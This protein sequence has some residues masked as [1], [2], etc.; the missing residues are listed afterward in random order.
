MGE[1]KRNETKK[2]VMGILAHVD[3]GKTTL[4]EGI[5]YKSGAIRKV[6]RVDKQDTFL[7][8]E[9]Q[10]RARGITIFSKQARFHWKK[11]EVTLLD[12]PG[13]VDF[14][15]EMERTLQVLDYAILVISALD[16]VQGHTQTL[17]NLLRDYEIPTFLFINKMDQPG[18]DREK[19][20]AELRRRLDSGCVDFTDPTTE[21]F[22]ENVATCE[23]EILE[24]YLE[25]GEIQTEAIRDVIV[26]RKLFP[27]F[28][29]SALKLEGI[30]TLLDGMETYTE[31]MVY[32]EAFSARVFKITRDDQGNR[33]T[34]MKVT[35]GSLKVKEM[36]RALEWEEKVNQIRLYSGAKYEPVQEAEAG[37]VCAV[38]GLTKTKP[39]E[40]LGEDRNENI[41]VLEPVLTYRICLPDEVDASVMLPKLRML[42]EEDPML[43][44]DWKEDLQ[45]IHAK[46]MGE[47]QIEVLTNLVKNRF[48]IDIT[49]DEGNIVYKET[50]ANTVEG[51][52]HFEPLRH[53]AEVHLLME[54]GNPGSGIVIEADCSED[55]LDRNW[56][57]LILTHLYEREHEGVLI[58]APITDVKITLKAGK[59]HL[60][61]T[62]GGD[63][64]QAT[65]RAVRQ[66]LR[67]AESVLLEPWYDFR[68]ELPE[69]NIGR[70]MMDVEKM[71]GKA[72][73]DF[74]EEAGMQEHLPPEER[75][76][77]LT[78]SCPVASMRGYPVELYSYTK[79]RGRLFC[80]LKGYAPCHNAE[81]II[82]AVGYVPEADLMNPTGSVFCSHGAGVNIPWDEVKKHMHLPS[83][84]TPK[85]EEPEIGDWKSR[86]LEER[87][88]GEDEVE[89]ILNRTF[90]SNQSGKS[91]KRRYKKSRGDNTASVMYFSKEDRRRELS[92][93]MPREKREEYLLVDGYNIVFAWEELKKLAENNID[94]ARDKLLDILS[95]YQGYKKC[96]L[97]V[98]FD[99]YR[100][101]GHDTEVVP[102]HN[103]TVVYTK[104]AE[105]ADS[106]IEK[107]AHKN[108]R[109][110]E[111]TVATSDRL[112]QMIILG[113]GC[114]ALSARNL[115]EEVQL[116]EKE[117]RKELEQTASREKNTLGASLTK[118]HWEKLR[119]KV[120]E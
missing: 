72:S 63:F 115:L 29:G 43:S 83:I 48:G 11:M 110:Y 39:G 86:E 102:Y 62:E 64:R 50:I 51:V 3:A 57:R 10:E 47:V 16:G 7:D 56:Q 6:G 52:G 77:V 82:E 71:Y 42:E 88:I 119:E 28:F 4:S 54:P 41:P 2:L 93:S 9:E 73:L 104:E 68:M 65:Y 20:L 107:F 13:H 69:T 12:T 114:R 106:F 105:T 78:G 85:K 97:M 17:W 21:E 81:E 75:M 55:L 118:E 100:I 33:L 37:C 18:A 19:I 58:G 95:N 113:Q 108:S 76:A 32:D 53:Y 99:A 91:A 84:L 61:H 26:E 35:G 14:S 1:Q 45:E 23:E 60:K 87:W 70:A 36:I 8:T 44:I 98:V 5:L 92:Y 22:C 74:D 89:A 31:E 34:H 80:T 94:S 67:Q 66:G 116:A 38:T 96:Q 112:E 24:A 27:C 103:I 15:T 46:L 109:Q 49:F 40:G 120:E 25:E 79:G 117:L 30:E 101:K 59:A 90:Y 111:I